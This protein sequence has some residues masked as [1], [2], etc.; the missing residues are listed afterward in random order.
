MKEFNLLEA[1]KKN[2]E[3][4]GLIRNGQRVLAAISGGLDSMVMAHLLLKGGYSF[5]MAYCHF[6][7]RPEADREE[8]FLKEFAAAHQI[9]FHST[10]FNTENYAKAKGISIQ[11]AARELRYEWFESV[12][13][14]EKYALIATAHHLNDQAETILLNLAKGTG[15]RGLRGMKPKTHYLIRP[16]LFASREEL[17]HYAKNEKIR[18]ME[19]QSNASDH[20]QRNFIRH[21]IIPSLLE[22]NPRFIESVRD[23]S[24]HLRFA[25]ALFNERLSEY[26]KKIFEERKDGI[27]I[28]LRKLSSYPYPSELLYELLAPYGFTM[29]QV[30][31]ALMERQTMSGQ[32]FESNSMRLIRSRDFLILTS[33]KEED[34]AY[35]LIPEGSKKIQ[36][37]GGILEMRTV[38]ASESYRPS[39]ELNKASLDLAQLEFPLTLRLWRAGDYFYPFGLM[40]KKSNKPGKKKISDYLNEMKLSPLEKE[41]IWVL[42][43]G[44]RIAWIPGYRIDH[45]FAVNEKSKEVLEIKYRPSIP[46]G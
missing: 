33:N 35:L 37:S 13:K 24:R 43:S 34:T 31:S 21:R 19:D 8:E 17:E 42:Q 3:E 11:M 2:I 28:P 46:N 41:R 39:K 45:R 12:R 7:L 36:F 5:G 29:N 26:R 9:P 14:T 25:E 32:I 1:F 20:Y 44:Q 4:E 16:L 38:Q 27:Y 6:G 22:I 15:I 18:W 40:K 30:S 10:R 23:S